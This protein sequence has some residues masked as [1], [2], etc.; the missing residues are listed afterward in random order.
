MSASY[1][2]PKIKWL[3]N[4]G[5]K[6]GRSIHTHLATSKIIPRNNTIT[7]DVC[8]LESLVI[9]EYVHS[10]NWVCESYDIDL[11]REVARQS[12]PAYIRAR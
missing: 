11:P 9:A 7:K 2:F 6:K 12:V 8:Y 5:L 3:E 10:I 1:E 4:L